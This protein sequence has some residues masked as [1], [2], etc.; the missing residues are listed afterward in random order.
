MM[1]DVATLRVA[2]A[3][4]AVTLLVLFYFV[5][6]RRTRSSYSA[7]WCLALALFLAGNAA[8][9][10][11][12]TPQQVWGNPAGNTLLVLGS[13]S[14]WAGARTLRTTRPKAW[15]LAA[16]P[17]ITAVVSAFDNPAVNDWSGGPIYLAGM[18]VMIALAAWELWRLEPGYSRVHRPLA[19]AAAFVAVYYL[20]R[21]MVFIVGGG[22]DSEVFT[23]YFG[24]AATTIFTMVLLVVASFS[25]A[26]LSNEQQTVDLMTRATQDGLTGLLNRTVFLDL[27]AEELRRLKRT[28]TK[29]SLI[30]ADLDHFKTVNDTHGHSAG[31]TALKA[32]AGACADTVRATDLVG[33]FGGEEFVILLAGADLDQAYEIAAE[34]SGRLRGAQKPDGFQMP[35][36]SYG[37]ASNGRGAV[38]LEKMLESADAALYRAKGLGRNQ[39]VLETEMADKA[40]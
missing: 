17:A 6:F 13:G 12:G 32:F 10:F 14:V 29:A 24:S 2:F 18:S 38:S 9:L 1:L 39:I 8:Y 16:A 25:M 5:T 30:L 27:A 28:G 22:P 15:Q 4:V 11:D 26:A 40:V 33:R 23:T 36:V 34:I 7:W 31:D 37:I 20:V 19:A 3:V 35:T 21:C